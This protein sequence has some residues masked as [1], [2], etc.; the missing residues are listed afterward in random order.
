MNSNSYFR[1]D[2]NG[3][4]ALSVVIVVLYHFDSKIVPGGFIG[5]DVFFVISGYLMTKIISSSIE[6]GGFNVF[7]FLYR[8]FKRLF[9]AL[10]F[11]CFIVY[12]YAFIYLTSVEFQEVSKHVVASLSFSS[13]F[14]YWLEAGYFDSSAATKWLLHTWSLSAEWQFYIIYPFILLLYYNVFSIKII[15][16]IILASFIIS[17]IV[18][19]FLFNNHPDAA[20]YLLPSRAWEMLLGGLALY[21]PLK[22]GFRGYVCLICLISIVASA[23]LIDS[24]ANWPGYIA[25]IPTVSAYIIIA[26]NWDWKLFENKYIQLIGL[27]SYSIYLVHWPLKVAG[28][29]LF[30]WCYCFYWTCRI[31]FLFYRVQVRHW[32]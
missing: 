19:L 27:W 14:I 20:Y 5:V 10:A 26:S 24:D 18:S 21:F 13:N 22:K 12:L 15:K 8:R 1:Y 28:F 29:D 11:L 3:L 25:L 17:F 2:I 30:L 31:Y 4:R 23:F 16:Y 7:T 9:P 32:Y 6:K